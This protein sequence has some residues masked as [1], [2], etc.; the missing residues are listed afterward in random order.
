[1]LVSRKM[2][3]SSLNTIFIHGGSGGDCVGGG[4]GGGD[5]GGGDSRGSG[6]GGCGGSD[7]C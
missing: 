3:S 6:G 1:M 5:C 4:S 2:N 7:G